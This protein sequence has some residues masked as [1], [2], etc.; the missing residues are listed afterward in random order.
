MLVGDRRPNPSAARH[1]SPERGIDSFG[2]PLQ[3]RERLDARK[4]FDPETFCEQ[5]QL[6]KLAFRVR[7]AHVADE[8]VTLYLVGVLR[9]QR[10]L[11]DPEQSELD[12]SNYMSFVSMLTQYGHTDVFDDLP[13][14]LVTSTRAYHAHISSLLA[15]LVEP[16][17]THRIRRAMASLVHAAADRERARGSGQPVLPFAVVLGDVVDG[18][19]GYLEAP[20]SAET[21]AA[22]ARA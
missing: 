3:M 1:G 9:I 21:L 6:S 14:D 18:I 12:D 17:R 4:H 11:V 19:V 16:L 20:A 22:I 2:F 7:P 15:H 8:R 13:D 10:E 5:G